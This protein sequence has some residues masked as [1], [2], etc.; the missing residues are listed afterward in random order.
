MHESGKA[1]SSS[2]TGPRTRFRRAQILRALGS[3][4]DPV[5]AVRARQLALDPRVRVNET[6]IPLQSQMREPQ[7]REGTWEWIKE[8][9]DELVARLS[10]R[11]SGG[12]PWLIAAFCDG[13]HAADA[14]AFFAPRI[15]SLPGGP[16]N[17]AGATET[18]RLC[19]ASVALHRESAQAFFADAG[20]AA[21]R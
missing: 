7:T 19:A 6:A 5:L 8:H 21:A 10:E 4:S 11:G 17:L 13:A 15:H 3:T 1:P 9:W 12:L 16:R 18:I 2:S 20:H 14:E